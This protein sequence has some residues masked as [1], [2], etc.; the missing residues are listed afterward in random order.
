MAP[1]GGH[2]FDP[3]KYPLSKVVLSIGQVLCYDV[4]ALQKTA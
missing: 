4:I 2:A 3:Y 1:F